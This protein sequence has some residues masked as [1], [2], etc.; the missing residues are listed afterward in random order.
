MIRRGD[1]WY[2]GG[3]Y[4]TGS[5]QRAG[6]PAIIV[7]NE[8]NNEHSATVEVVYLTTQPKRDLPTHAV[9]QSLGKE[10]TAIC[11]QITTVSIERIGNYM[12]RITEDEMRNVEQ[13][14]LTSLELHADAYLKEVDDP[15]IRLVEIKAKYDALQQMYNSL[16]DK[17]V[18]AG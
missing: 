16:V 2:I 18:R 13:A 1:V 5:E 8:K 14:M 10:S 15:Q 9:I 12:G 6:R 17:L 4:S 3:G 7:S 11:E